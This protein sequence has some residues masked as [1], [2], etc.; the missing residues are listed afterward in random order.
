MSWMLRKEDY[1][2]IVHEGYRPR[3]FNLRDDPGELNDLIGRQPEM[4]AE[5][6]AIIDAQVDRKATL[7]AWEEWRRHNFMQFRRQAK[8]GLYFDNTYGL[9]EKPSS[10]Y[11]EIID[12]ALTGW[13][14]EDERRVDEW[15]QQ[16]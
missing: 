13:T 11:H 16:R 1:K 8:R 4:A 10:D 7:K 5:L 9:R 15:M 14:E 6:L 2:L 12:N 3:L